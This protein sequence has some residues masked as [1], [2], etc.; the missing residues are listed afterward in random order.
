MF[1][2]IR[3]EVFAAK[4]FEI[5]LVRIDVRE[6]GPGA[7]DLSVLELDADGA[8]VFSDNPLDWRS[9]KE[10]DLPQFEAGLFRK[11]DEEQM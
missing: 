6:D 9:S 2:K 10:I 4:Q 7:M 3:R 11:G 1:R 5:C 8:P